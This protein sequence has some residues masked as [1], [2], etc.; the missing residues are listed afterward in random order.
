MGETIAE[1]R[2]AGMELFREMVPTPPPGAEGQAPSQGTP[3]AP[4]IGN[5]AAENVFGALWTRPG[6]SRRDRSLVT[7]GIL[8]A[9]RAESELRYHFPIALRNGVTREELEEVIYQATG[10][11]GFPAATAARNAAMEVLPKK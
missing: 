5:L 6:L 10:Y 1:R 4:E 11:A 9:L 3:F 2:E 7:I 8:I